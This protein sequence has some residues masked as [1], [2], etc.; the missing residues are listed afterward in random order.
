MDKRDV[1]CRFGDTVKAFRSELGI[2][3]EEL[4][5]RSG[6]H[7]TYISDVERG[8]RNVSLKT[9]EKLAIALEISVSALFP[10]RLLVLANA[11]SPPS[12]L[13]NKTILP[14]PCDHAVARF[15][16]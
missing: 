14:T 7:R 16:R 8:A 12:L 13:G 1:Q 2:S 15:G 5:G 3:Q 9:I 10:N 4:A 11:I 6:L